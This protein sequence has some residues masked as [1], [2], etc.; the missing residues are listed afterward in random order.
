MTYKLDDFV[1]RGSSLRGHIHAT[2]DELVKVFGEP[3]I[4]NAEEGDKVFNEWGIRFEDGDDDV[5]ATIYDWKEMYANESH[6]GEYR[7]HIGG[8]EH[9]AVELVYEALGK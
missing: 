9:R 1:P 2:Y 8:K 7:W 4:L 5:Y 6:Y 3:N